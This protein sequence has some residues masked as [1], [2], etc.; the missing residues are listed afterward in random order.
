MSFSELKWL[1]RTSGSVKVFLHISQFV[2]TPFFKI[3][4]TFLNT[5]YYNNYYI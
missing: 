1:F 2:P 3:Y 5:I 4:L